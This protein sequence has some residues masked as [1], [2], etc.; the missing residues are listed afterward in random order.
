[1]FGF[2]EL[3]VQP[4][5]QVAHMPDLLT[6]T[7]SS[8]ILFFLH[9]AGTGGNDRKSTKLGEP[10]NRRGTFEKLSKSYGLLAVL[11]RH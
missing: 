5:R 3:F 10:H 1:M 9:P 7:G 4:A 8:F 2:N 11:L 6:S